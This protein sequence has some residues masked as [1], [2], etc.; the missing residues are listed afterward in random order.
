[1]RVWKFIRIILFVSLSHLRLIGDHSMIKKKILYVEDCQDTRNLIY[2]Q[3]TS[4]SYKNDYEL[5]TAEDGSIGL[6]KF[7]NESPDLII[8]DIDMPVMTG[9]EM[10]RNIRMINKNIP[11]IIA[12]SYSLYFIERFIKKLNIADYI[13]K[14][15]DIDTLFNRVDE[16]SHKILKS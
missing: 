6:T 2:L 9:I 5:L 11:I 12:S 14:P 3:F 16:I 4:M 15:F 1:M 8:S 13:S 7:H 10:I